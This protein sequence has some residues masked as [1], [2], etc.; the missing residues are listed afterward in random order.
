MTS[1]ETSLWLRPVWVQRQ[2]L[3]LVQ[4]CGPSAPRLRFS[5]SPGRLLSNTETPDITTLKGTHAGR[6]S[7]QRGPV[8]QERIEHSIARFAECLAETTSIFN[9]CRKSATLSP[10]KEKVL[11]RTGGLQVIFK[12]STVAPWTE[13]T[14]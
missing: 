6:G 2:S 9:C 13:T 14:S 3:L 4:K 12:L 1:A 10:V 8:A 11:Q 7:E 5:R